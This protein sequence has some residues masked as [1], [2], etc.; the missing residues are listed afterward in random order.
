MVVRGSLGAGQDFA[1]LQS[2]PF[3]SNLPAED[4]A[5]L[6]S[7]VRRRSFRRNEVVFHRDDPGT[8]LYVIRSGRVKIS[9]QNEEGSEVTLA[10][11]GPGDFFGEMALLD[12]MPRSATAT[13][14]ESTEV[15]T[16]GRDQFLSAVAQH[17]QIAAQVMAALSARLRNA[18]QMIE[19]I[20]TRDIS[21]RLARKL[22]EIAE[23]HGTPVSD[24]IEVQAHL[25]QQDL[26]SMV[27]ATRESV[28]KVLRAYIVKGWVT[29]DGHRMVINNLDE[30]R[31]R[32]F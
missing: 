19:D 21:A 28:N 22:V 23:Q 10:L 24:G 2:V 15:V 20:V 11:L 14:Q 32:V 17:P 1:L 25:T 16:L 26:A 31:R 6:A 30:L 29:S 12:D 9:L 4:L 5:F 3:L 27:G 13:A 8:M 7:G 18:D